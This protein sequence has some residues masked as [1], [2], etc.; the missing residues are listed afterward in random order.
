MNVLYGV[1]P[2]AFDCPGGGERQLMAYRQHLLDQGVSVD[3]YDMWSP[4]LEN[5]DL[6]HF[7]SVM[8]GSIQLCN[9]VQQRGLPVIV[10]PNLWVTEKTKYQ[11]PHQDI[12]EL[13]ALA[14][15]IVV[16]SN[17]EAQT[18]S[19]V[20]ALPEDRF[21][22]VYNGVEES[23]FDEVSGDLFREKFGLGDVP[24]VLN[25]ANVEPRKNQLRFLEALID[26]PEL[27][28]VNIGHVRD[29]QYAE[30]CLSKGEDSFIMLG[31][32]PYAS[33]L[34][35]SAASAC[36]FFAMPSILETPSIAA[37]EAGAAGAHVLITEVGSTREYFG[38]FAVYVD[39]ENVGSMREG[40][41]QALNTEPGNHLRDHIHE[42][43]LWSVVSNKLANVYEA[44]LEAG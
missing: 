10:S 14:D 30:E 9:H 4:K 31:A 25:V 37:L 24:F 33:K 7:F 6:F 17:A 39:P 41:K 44:V 27:R 2:W 11:Y 32:V 23:F 3:L 42:Q 28:L 35:A 21:H 22:V 40:I 34:L 16:N 19:S 12:L 5:Y 38:E 1:Y 29:K 18:L 43:F 26:F 20:Y 8:P 13:L 36:S 15:A